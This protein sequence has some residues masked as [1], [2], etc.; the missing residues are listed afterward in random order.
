[1]GLDVITSVTLYNQ[2]KVTEVILV[3]TA[4]L[5]LLRIWI[6]LNWVTSHEA[7]A[8]ERS[9]ALPSRG[10]L[11]SYTLGGTTALQED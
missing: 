4:I 6:N 2:L 3:N 11:P 1:M 8:V 7:A 10:S 5:S 9:V